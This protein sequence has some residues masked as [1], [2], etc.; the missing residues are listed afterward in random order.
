MPVFKAD[1]GST[2]QPAVDAR[3]LHRFLGVKR[4]FSNWI[5]RRITKCGLVEG[6]DYLLT[7]IGE[8]LPSGTKYRFEYCLKLDV[9][10]E[11]SM[12]E[13]TPKALRRGGISSIVNAV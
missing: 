6:S 8:Q 11:L 10:K 13:K 5:K 4:D 12:V 7:K 9:A 2:L 3:E 1:I